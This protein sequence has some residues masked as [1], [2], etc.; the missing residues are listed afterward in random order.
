MK[1]EASNYRRSDA[2][3]CQENPDDTSI[4]EERHDPQ[5]E[6]NNSKQINDKGMLRGKCSP[7]LMNNFSQV[8]RKVVQMGCTSKQSQTTLNFCPKLFMISYRWE[9]FYDF[10]SV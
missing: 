1:I 3:G 7:M 2:F 10:V 8:I 5:E 6:E 9:S 4:S